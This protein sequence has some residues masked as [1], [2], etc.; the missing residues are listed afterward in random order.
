MVATDDTART[1]PRAPRGRYRGTVEAGGATITG[2]SCRRGSDCGRRSVIALVT[3]PALART[4][5]AA[6]RLPH[7]PTAFAPARAPPQAELDWDNAS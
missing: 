5:L 3:D 1:M 7:E 2:K 6:L 4:L